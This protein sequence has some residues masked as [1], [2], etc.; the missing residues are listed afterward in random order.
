MSIRNDL[1]SIVQQHLGKSASSLF[2]DKCLAILNES[3][4]DKE[5]YLA[6]AERIS[7]R[8]A[9]FIDT[10]LARQVFESLREEISKSASPPGTR[11]RHARVTLCKKVF[12]TRGGISHELYTETLSAGGMYIRKKEPF[13]T[14]SEIDIRIP[15]EEGRDIQL[16]GLVVYT[17]N[18]FSDTSQYPP[19]MA[20]EFKGVKDEE[21][22]RVRSYVE[23]SLTQDMQD[24]RGNVAR[25][26]SRNS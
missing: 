2:L 5:S 16:R 25:G 12:V 22:T 4:D 11:R 10:D 17:R 6:A 21:M 18:N 8:T 24:D 23:Q 13:P 19:G 1:K 9:L 15:L 7:S 20:I 3:A 14:G 26:P